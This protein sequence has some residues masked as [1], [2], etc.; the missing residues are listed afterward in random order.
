MI[1]PQLDVIGG[2][3]QMTTDSNAGGSVGANQ[4][5][6]GDYEYSGYNRGHLYPH[7]NSCDQKQEESTFTLTNAAP[8]K[9]ADN[10]QWYHQVEKLQQNI[11][12][13]CSKNT[14]YVV[15][16][17]IPGNNAI[18]GGVHIPTHYWSA[19]CCRDVKNQN[20]FISQ[21]YMLEMT[22]MGN[23]QATYPT[24]LS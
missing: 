16:G 7:C 3:D 8:Q 10:T 1:E 23:A 2:P 9:Q 14:A 17:V 21:G 18:K 11:N 6:D 15:T 5:V 13:L 12:T 4:A 20:R 24:Q 22:G 19:Y